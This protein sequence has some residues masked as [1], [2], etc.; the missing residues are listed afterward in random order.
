MKRITITLDKKY[1]K[2]LSKIALR[3]NRKKVE[4]IRYLIDREHDSLFIGNKK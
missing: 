4:E 1:D 3:E 2:K